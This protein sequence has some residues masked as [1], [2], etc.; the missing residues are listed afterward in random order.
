MKVFIITEGSRTIGLGHITR[1]TSLYQAFEEKGVIPWFI[2]NGDETLRE[3][4]C[5][6][7]HT[8]LNWTEKQGEVSDLVKGAHVVIIDSYLADF[9]F[10]RCISELAKVPVYIDD[11]KRLDYP[12]GIVVNG[13]IYAQDAI[14]YPRRDGVVYFLGSEYMPLRRD[15]WHVP[16][17]EIRG[18]VESIMIT[19]GGD[20]AANMTPEVLKLVVDAYP[21]CTKSVIIGKGFKDEGIREIDKLKDKST[22][23]IC[24]PDAKGMKKVMIE[25]DVAISACGQTLYELARIGLPTIAVA[26]AENQLYNAKGWQKAGFIRYAGWWKD[27]EI[28]ENVKNGLRLLKNKKLREKMS[29]TGQVF[30]D[31]RGSRRILGE[32]INRV[33]K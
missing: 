16:E 32:I 28:L 9:D 12:R 6:K 5:D 17:K 30:V 2:V 27:R 29:Q 15:F 13:T 14:D 1:C 26:V 4:L 19:F 11:V 3:P 21:A 18:N 8:I 20:D 10:Y 25:S 33:S 7:N 22:S 23:L 31:G 24:C